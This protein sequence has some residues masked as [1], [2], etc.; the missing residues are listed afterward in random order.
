M[1]GMSLNRSRIS[2]LR[3]QKLYAY[4]ETA[5]DGRPMPSRDELDPVEMRF[6][7]GY[8]ALID[9]TQHP[10]RYRV[11]LQGTELERWVGRD[12]TG[13]TLDELPYPETRAVAYRCLDAVVESG[14]PYH[15]RE[16]R[17]LE[18]MLRDFEVLVLPLSAG[19]ESVAILLAAIR[20]RG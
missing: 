13:Q 16:S 9:V 1:A 10:P 14:L 5:C 6:I 4:W 3:L 11:R 20:C 15:A 12:L 18:E 8:L 2:D 19:G 7:L 17:M